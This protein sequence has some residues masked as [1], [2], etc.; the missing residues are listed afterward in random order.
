MQLLEK[1]YNRFKIILDQ[2]QQAR[3]KIIQNAT[4]FDMITDIKNSTRYRQSQESK[5]MLQ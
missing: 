4:I 1:E 5:R 2:T 3:S